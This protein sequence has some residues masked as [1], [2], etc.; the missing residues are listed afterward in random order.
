MA[1]TS[2]GTGGTGPART[3]ARG[4]KSTTAARTPTPADKLDALIKAMD[5][6]ELADQHD[7][8]TFC[9]AGRKL[10]HYLAVVTALAAGELEAGAKEMAKANGGGFTGAFKMRRVTRKLNGAAD[11]FGSAAGAF[12][13]TWSEFERVFEE[14]LSKSSSK[15]KAHRRFTITP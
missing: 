4:A 11:H 1:S 2:T 7:L 3:A 8:N 10:S 6:I 13:A 12:V 9:E 14:M 5:D 15:P